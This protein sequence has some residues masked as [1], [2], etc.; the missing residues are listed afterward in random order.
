MLTSRGQPVFEF[1]RDRIELKGGNKESSEPAGPAK[2]KVATA[3][4]AAE[5]E[6]PSASTDAAAA[7]TAG[8]AAVA[9]TSAPMA[10]SL[11]VAK[12]R[13]APEIGEPEDVR[14][15]SIG[16]A[17][18]VTGTRVGRAEPMMEDDPAGG[19]DPASADWPQPV[20]RGETPVSVVSL[21]THFAPT[22]PMRAGAGPSEARHPAAQ[23]SAEPDTTAPNVA[24]SA[25]VT[26]G[27]GSAAVAA[28]SG[29]LPASTISKLADQI[30]T[31]AEAIQTPAA[32]APADIAAA[33]VRVLTVML[34]PPE[35][36][37][38]VVRL[39]KRDGEIAI[40]LS[41]GSEETTR[42]LGRDR[43]RIAGLLRD[44]GLDAALTVGA[45][46]PTAAAGGTAPDNALAQANG[47]PP[48]GGSSDAGGSAARRE[49]PPEG[50]FTEGN[51]QD[52]DPQPDR[53]R[54][55]LYV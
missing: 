8:I 54:G 27:T 30:A 15:I 24:D 46:A 17:S 11:D 53:R 32:A 4:A 34:N 42:L 28:D 43:E 35:Y 52:A 41:A 51:G 50:K 31:A 3:A 9:A 36:G 23:S 55:A 29:G 10:A 25:P 18:L 45:P 44:S 12:S 14:A 7:F 19:T 5:T 22:M 16:P 21:E 40:S 26:A 38:V 2:R 37:A 33:P 48:G 20:E 49:T 39:R 13:G 47:R 1:R 6:Q